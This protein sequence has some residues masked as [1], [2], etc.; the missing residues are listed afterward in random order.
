MP[1]EVLLLKSNFRTAPLSL[2]FVRSTL[3]V[4]LKGGAVAVLN[5]KSL[6]SFKLVSKP[7]GLVKTVQG[8][9]TPLSLSV[10]V[11][12]GETA[13]MLTDFRDPSSIV[14]DS[15]GGKLYICDPA[16]RGGAGIVEITISQEKKPGVGLVR[17]LCR[18]GKATDVA[19]CH[20]DMLVAACGHKVVLLHCKGALRLTWIYMGQSIL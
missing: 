9:R 3:Y 19:L 12:S 5:V 7:A 6:F 10:T 2:D 17:L 1:A 8:S 20:R 16:M 18:L 15:D 14:G 11:T 13:F 4:L